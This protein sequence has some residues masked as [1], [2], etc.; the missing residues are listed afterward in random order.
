MPVQSVLLPVGEDLYAVPAH[1]VR[2][3]VA[4]PRPTR[5]PTTPPTLLG[6]INLRGE[7]VPLFNTAALLGLPPTNPEPS[8]YAI[9]LHTARGPAA[10]VVDDLPRIAALTD[11]IG[12]SELPGTD[13]RF[14]VDGGIAVLLHFERLIA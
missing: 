8:P 14:A 6:V 1:L 13:G 3:V 7:V 10:L 5:L 12:P 2:E 11:R 9:V 4:V